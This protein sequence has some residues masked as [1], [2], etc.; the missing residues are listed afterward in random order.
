MGISVRGVVSTK[1][2]LVSHQNAVPLL[3]EITIENDGE[4]GL[5]DLTLELEPSLPFVAGKTWL[6]D[7]LGPDSSITV[8]DRDVELREGYLA[9][10]TEGVQTSV[11]LRLRSGDDILAEERFPVEL[12]ARS[13]WGGGG[14]M[15]E[16]LAAFC[17]PNDPEVDRVLKSAS[18]VLRRAGRPDAIDG[19]EGGSRKRVWELTSAIWS[20]VCGYRISYVLPP[21]GFEQDGQKVRPPSQVLDLRV[22]TCL[23]TAL[24]FAA[25]L[26]QA[27]LNPVI[28][29][30]KGHAFAGVWL[31]PQEFAQVLNDDASAVRKRVEL[32]EMLVFET[33]LATQSSPPAFGYAADTAS[34]QLTDEDFLMALDVHRARMQKLRPLTTSA[35]RAGE[36]QENEQ[37]PQMSEALE[38]APDLPTFDVEVEEAPSTPTGKLELWQR[39]LLDLTTRNRMLHLPDRAKV[40]RLVCPDPG[41]LEDLLAADKKV[42]IVPMPD[43]EVGGRDSET[44]ARRNQENLEEETARQCM[45]RKEVLSRM[46]KD[47]LEARLVD[48]FRKAK[49]DL[50]EGGS[51]TLFLAVGFLRWKKAEDDPRSYDAP[52]IL[53]PV[54]LERKS[55]ISPVRM[56]LL[57]DEPR[58]NLTLLELLRHDFQLDI[59]GLDGDLPRD[60]SG[61]DVH[62]IWNIVR[63]AVRD[64]PGFEVV[65]DVVLGTFSFSKYLMW[66]DLLDRSE[67][68]MENEV[69][70]HLLNHKLGESS[71]E[72]PGEFPEPGGLDQ[73]IE[74]KDLFTPLPADSSQLAAVVASS[75]GH[76][77]VLDG[78]PGTGKSQTIANMIAHNLAFGR[79]VLFVAEKM[80]A[81]DVVKRRLD[82]KGIGQFSL[83]LHSSKSSKKHVLEQLDRTWTVSG[84][85]GPGENDWSTQAEKVRARRDRLNRM[86][87]ALHR[88]WPNGWS[89]HE[90]IG[91]VVRDTTPS[92]PRFSWSNNI[93]HDAEQMERLRDVA[94]RLDLNREA[95]ES[96]GDQMALVTC[97]EWSNAWQ[98][99]MVGAARRAL[100]AL[101]ACDQA[102]QAV[103]HQTGL[104]TDDPGRMVPLARLLPD[105]HGVE[106][107]FAFSPTRKKTLEAVQRAVPLLKDYESLE[108]NLSQTYAREAVRHID[109]DALRDEWTQA[110]GK[111]WPLRVLAKRKV[112]KRLGEKAQTPERPDV[113]ADLSHLAGMKE[114]VAEIDGLDGDLSDVPGWSALKT[115]TK[116]MV[117]AAE[118]GKDLRAR[119]IPLAQSPDRLVDLRRQVE[120]I[121]VDSNE[122]LEADGP[123]AESIRQ[124]TSR[125]EDLSAAAEAF[126]KAAGS[127]I[128]LAFQ[129]DDLRASARAVV[130]NE[131]ALNAWSSWQRVRQEAVSADLGPLIEAVEQGVLPKGS[132][133]DAFEV[134]YARWFAS[135]AIDAEPALRQFVPAEHQSDVEAY[136]EAVDELAD[137][138]S[139][140]IR[141]RLSGGIPDKNNVTKR[142][143]FGILKHELQKKQRH[144][145][146]RQ[147]AQEMGEDFTRLAPCMLMSPLSIAQYLPADHE[148][149]DLVIFDE[150][151]QITPWDAVGSIARGKQVVIAGDSCQ[152]PPTNFFNR[153]TD[154]GD[155]DTDEDMESIL[156]ECI[157]AGVPEHSL[158]WH[159]RSRHE[160]LITFSNYRYYD[161]RLVTFPA[162]DTR[163][164][165]VTWRKVDGVYSP[166]KGG[167]KNPIEAKAIVDEVVGRLTDPEFVAAGQSIGIITLNSDQ[168]QLV[169]D[170]LDQAR[171]ENRRIERFF[172]GDIAEPVMVK[173]LETMQGDERD[174][175]ILGIGFGPTEP[176]ANTMSMNFGPLN[177]DGGWRRLNVA[178]TRARKEMMVFTSFDPS[179]I[180][181]NR[182]SASAVQDL[183]HF[184]EFAHEG[185]KAITSAVRGSVGDYDSPFE[186]FV[187]DGLRAKG[188]EVH[189]QIG[190]SRFRIDLGVVHPDRP[191]D[192]LV[193]VECDGATYHSAATARDR[194]KVRAEILRGL[195]WHLVRVWSTEWWIDRERALERL[196]EGISAELGEQ[197]T[198]AVE[199]ER[200]QELDGVAVQRAIVSEGVGIA[201]EGS[202]SALDDPAEHIYGP[203]GSEGRNETD[204]DSMRLIARGPTDSVEAPV[205][206]TYRM[207]D[208]SDLT[209]TLQPDSFHDAFYDATL[210]MLIHR[211][212][213]HEAPILDKAL[214]D[215]VARVHSFKRSGR[216]I[217][218]RVLEL[219]RRHYHFQPDLDPDGGDFVWLAA[220]DPRR[221]NSYR[222]PGREEDI[223]F[224][225]ELPPEEILAAARSLA[226]EDLA[227][228]TARVFGIR[229]LSAGAKKRITR[230]LGMLEAD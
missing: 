26:E 142:S 2:G 23:D 4:K 193:G 147:L 155:D 220:D 216:R 196:H 69:V 230:V 39:K 202:E 94:R 137:M 49:T 25:A 72:P 161:G 104:S 110:S 60:E 62:G 30:T 13:Q 38:A 122:M 175:I 197:R 40:I 41:E 159:Y 75:Q 218:E 14:S 70:H 121:V 189:P 31:Q 80:A 111:L 5:D 15:P 93:E 67:Q 183:R 55:A 158:T 203:K 115:D 103:S 210:E 88:R 226:T 59:P 164:S 83:E 118:L 221:W 184:I 81:L 54:R 109:V 209:P 151:S 105:A 77:F 71:L 217:R 27:G 119:L 128:D 132:V 33:T 45:A 177:R 200:A 1:L 52:L 79:R 28:L 44:Y 102:C 153:G 112:A 156:D 135:K 187:A 225:D 3:R 91:L 7:R 66:R 163:P 227:V 215:R 68:L 43:L 149:F 139:A 29:L 78:P 46:D 190:V 198:R 207:A 144:K 100:S 90:A 129:V 126:G 157:G 63:R 12:L 204:F 87:E 194:D 199:M 56:S 20:A 136:R 171:R 98:E 168:Q 47:K 120:R 114:I 125:Y 107:R 141:A 134:A 223:R 116:R 42:R 10:L 124:L 36:P 76:N 224:A 99:A 89:V 35:H 84:R 162:A 133:S 228:E 95:V 21:A 191:G 166:G 169:E 150:A 192:Y 131:N 32:Q 201:E 154:S 213:E 97:T 222:V 50:D 6:I 74:P 11:H 181:L 17:M 229:R 48:L 205:K 86:V 176:E 73:L 53:L 113:E 170:L 9:D 85:Q 106:L 214:V 195:G 92:T 51:N 174:L 117:S 179:M 185:P 108:E 173:N 18:D 182:T 8:T 146:V 140:Y 64:M 206:R 160:S 57:D 130:E 65:T 34:K 127:E 82:E 16:L 22:G 172:G 145:P 186:G 180:D 178:V 101:D 19:Y 58:F 96:L 219:A 61:I 211:V 148:L 123:L 208:V 143:G 167:R 24:L 212:L 37:A 165:M 188:W 152:M 138:T